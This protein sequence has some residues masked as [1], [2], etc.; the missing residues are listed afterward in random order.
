M[1]LG[2]LSCT[3]SGASVNGLSLL[4]KPP[5]SEVR[6][7]KINKNFPLQADSLLQDRLAGHDK[8]C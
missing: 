3:H 2:L 4:W 7:V 6:K 8:K 1:K 5:Y